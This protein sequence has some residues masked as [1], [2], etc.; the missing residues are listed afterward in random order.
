MD[1]LK[2]LIQKPGDEG[3]QNGYYDGWLHDHFVSC[4]YVFV[5][6]GHIVAQTLNNPKSWH[7]SIC[8][9]NGDLYNTLEEVY[10]RVG[11]KCVVDSA[12]SQKR[13]PFLIKSGKRKMGETAA[14]RTI[15]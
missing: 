3:I 1:G 5:P 12:F 7:N 2:V 4:V 13:C 11:G 6:S 8:A 14:R 15:R 10:Q 9:V